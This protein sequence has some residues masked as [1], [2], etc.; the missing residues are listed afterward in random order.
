MRIMHVISTP[1]SGGAEVYVKDLSLAMVAAGHS[2]HITFLERA[3]ECGR[4]LEYERNFLEQLSAGGIS[5]AFL[6]AETRRRP[7]RGATRLRAEVTRFAPDVVH[8]HLYYVLMFAFLLPRRIPV[9]M[10]VHSIELGAPNWMFRLFDRRVSA[11]IGICHACTRK[12]EPLSSRPVVQIDN[13]VSGARLKASGWREASVDAPVQLAA[14]G[15]L[16]DAKQYSLMLESCARL[17]AQGLSFALRI[18]GEGP[19]KDAL[20]AQIDTLQLGEHVTLM[21]NISDVADL[22]AASDVFIMSSAWE[23]LPISL[24]EATL[25]GLPVLVTNVGGCA[26]VVHRVGNGLVV[27]EQTPA[28]YSEALA[29]LVGD[30]ELRRSCAR[31]ARRH[32][33]CYHINSAV[34]GHLTLYATH[35]QGQAASQ[36]ETSS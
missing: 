10:T 31:N 23:G 19:H 30:V 12:L 25:S 26:E 4:D 24:L 6:G 13:A 27:D 3:E 36:F 5:Y 1:A 34:A 29:R 22:L 14:I 8:C 35:Q 20:L 32:G 21:G 11:Y 16:T 2:V 28:R 15:R 9:V 7:W 33:G 18:A 17:K